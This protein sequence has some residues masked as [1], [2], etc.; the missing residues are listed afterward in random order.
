MTKKFFVERIG[1]IPTV[2]RRDGDTNMQVAQHQTM[3]DA[4][5]EAA[6]RNLNDEFAPQ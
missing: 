6:R 1:G 5:A 4:K 3:R 2:L